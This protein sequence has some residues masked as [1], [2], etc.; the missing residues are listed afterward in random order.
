MTSD[1][2]V[3]DIF[4]ILSVKLPRMQLAHEIVHKVEVTYR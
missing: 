1:I 3:T 4:S 2:N